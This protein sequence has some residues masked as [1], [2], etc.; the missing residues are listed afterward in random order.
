[1]AVALKLIINKILKI[2]NN[3][4]FNSTIADGN[5]D[6][7]FK[8]IFGLGFDIIDTSEPIYV[9]KF[10]FLKKNMNSF[11]VYLKLDERFFSY[12]NKIQ[13][14]YHTLNRFAFNYKV[15]KAPIVVKTDMMLN[16]L[17]ENDKNVL[18]IYQNN[19][20]YLFKLY[21]LLKIINMSLIHSQEFF[22]QPLCIKN[23]YNNLPFG[24]NILYYIH[25]FLTEKTKITS[26]ISHTDL[27][28][29]FHSCNFNLTT[30]LN[31]YEYLL[32]EKTIFNYVKNSLADILY[33]DI[34]EMLKNFNNNK[35]RKN[36][37]S[38]NENFP[39]NKIIQVFTP[40]L[41]LY[42]NSKYLLIPILKYKATNDLEYKL[43]KFQK[44][45]PLFGRLKIIYSEK[46]YRDGKRRKFKV[47]EEYNEKHINFNECDNNNFLKDH[48][49]YRYIHYTHSENNRYSINN[50]FRYINFNEDTINNDEYNEDTMNDDEDEQDTMD[51]EDTMDNEDTMDD[52][53]TM[54]E[55]DTTND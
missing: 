15:K 10:K 54:D 52:E 7:S 18:C 28:L 16:E 37:I 20:R 38:I 35:T 2:D 27:F 55:Q 14:T 26:K 6:P 33:K 41:G 39:K 25:Y 24:K 36:I 3:N 23:P 42:F 30:F 9:T 5:I 44:F 34:I 12:F 40:Y 4:F 21:D 13:R 48:L 17:E 50:I 45:N 49:T 51:D 29:K 46:I 11:L 47:K 8:V 1:M 31:N 19:S 53:D 22:S 32:R 43:A